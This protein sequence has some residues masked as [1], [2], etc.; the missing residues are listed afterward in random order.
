[1][2]TRV[3]GVFGRAYIDGMLD[4]Y[5]G[6]GNLQTLPQCLPMEMYR[7]NPTDIAARRKFLSDGEQEKSTGKHGRTAS[8]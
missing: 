4:H 8:H 1:M 6:L 2:E 5:G 3:R 7:V